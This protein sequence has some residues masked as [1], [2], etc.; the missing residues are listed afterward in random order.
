[1]IKDYGRAHMLRA[2]WPRY[3]LGLDDIDERSEARV[4]WNG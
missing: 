3:A 2:R 1:M 4:G